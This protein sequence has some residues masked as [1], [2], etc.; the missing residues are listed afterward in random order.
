MERDH[1]VEEGAFTT[2]VGRKDTGNL[3]DFKRIARQP[4]LHKYRRREYEEDKVI[5]KLSF[6]TK[7]RHPT[8]EAKG[9]IE[10]EF[11]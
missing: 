7:K 5:R 11:S 10:S 9:S 6:D 8:P 1:S 2:N 3:R 4:F